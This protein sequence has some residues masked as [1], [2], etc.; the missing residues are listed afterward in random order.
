MKLDRIKAAM[1]SMVLLDAANPSAGTG[2][3][4]AVVLSV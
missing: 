2:V 3:C 4:N 1:S